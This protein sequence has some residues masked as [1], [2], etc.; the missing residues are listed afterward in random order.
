M[1]TCSEVNG[2]NKTQWIYRGS[3]A[4]GRVWEWQEVESLTYYSIKLRHHH[5]L[6][7]LSQ[8][9]RVHFLRHEGI[10]IRP[11]LRHSSPF[12]CSGDSR[13]RFFSVRIPFALT[14]NDC[15]RAFITIR[16]SPRGAVV[17][18]LNEHRY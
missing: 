17:P 10:D 4:H 18:G 7:V 12:R 5:L 8:P 9:L 13:L 11:A 15:G 16:Q 14:V 3:P 6:L 1:D 2:L